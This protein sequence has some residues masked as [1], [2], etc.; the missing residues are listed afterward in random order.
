M[1]NLDEIPWAAAEFLNDLN[2]APRETDNGIRFGPDLTLYNWAVV[3]E[4]GKELERLG[5]K[6]QEQAKE[7]AA[8]PVCVGTGTESCWR[9]RLILVWVDPLKF[10]GGVSDIIG[11]LNCSDMEAVGIWHWVNNQ[12]EFVMPVIPNDLEHRGAWDKDG[13]FTKWSGTLKF[14]LSAPGEILR[15]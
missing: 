2:F 1:G 6:L 10:A 13:I 11:F 12:R 3:K 7:A 8:G 4:L 9:P 5:Q 15:T 14:R